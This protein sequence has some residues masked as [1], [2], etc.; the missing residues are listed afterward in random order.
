[1]KGKMLLSRGALDRIASDQSPLC[2]NSEVPDSSGFGSTGIGPAA[3]R[4]FQKRATVQEIA[5]YV[6]MYRI[7]NSR[8]VER[9]KP[10][11]INS[12]DDNAQFKAAKELLAEIRAT[13]MS[14]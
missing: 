11:V 8:I 2:C 13:S 1:M 12:F 6:Q 9:L 10:I 5:F 14:K 4:E 3:L 7:E